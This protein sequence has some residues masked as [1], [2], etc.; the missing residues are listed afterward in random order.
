VPQA[1]EVVR[2]RQAA[3]SGTD[4]DDVPAGVR[5]RLWELPA[6]RDREIAEEALDRVDADRFVDLHAV[7]CRLAGVVADPAHDGRQWVHCRQFPPGA[8][9][10]SVLRGSQPATDVLAGRARVLARRAKL[11]PDRPLG[12]PGA[13]VVGQ[14]GPGL[15]RNGVRQTGH[16][17]ASSGRSS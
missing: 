11:G 8:L 6:V 12:T 3:R 5:R 7:A 17:G 14:A 2:R 10:V 9:V 4:D 15:Q 16:L 13:R 1:P